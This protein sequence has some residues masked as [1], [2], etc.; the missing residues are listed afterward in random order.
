MIESKG[1]TIA[2]FNDITRHQQNDP[3]FRQQI[4]AEI[5]KLLQ[6]GGN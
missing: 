4:Q 1:L 6:S 3:R 2:Q 5:L